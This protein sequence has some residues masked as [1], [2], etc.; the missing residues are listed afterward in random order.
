MFDLDRFIRENIKNLIPYASARS[1]HSRKDEVFL[2][3]NENSMGD[4]STMVEG[5]HPGMNR[6]P[7]PFQKVLKEKISG[8]KGVPT[9][10]IFIGN[11]SDEA[12]DLIFRIFC[13]PGKDR[14]II[15]PPTYGMYEV[16][17]N[18]NDVRVCKV[19][20]DSRF[21]PDSKTIMESI[22]GQTKLIFLCSPN[23][24]SGNLVNREII[25]RLAASFNGI[26]VVDEAYIDFSGEKSLVEDLYSRPNVIIL[27]TLSKAWAMAGLRIGMAFASKPIIDLFNKVKP[28]YNISTASQIMAI[29]ALNNVGIK[30]QW[31]R[32]ILIERDRLS[33]ELSRISYVIRIYPSDANYILVR[34]SDHNQVY[35][36]L[37]E[38]KIV[39][40]DRSSY[41]GCEGCL[42]ITIGT[43][44]END[45]VLETLKR[46]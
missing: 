46:F 10:N 34:F 2:D 15:C 7:D 19:N 17:A 35:K 6:Y 38:N 31:L 14:V 43:R 44:E 36:A 3:A 8:V 40:R 11:G 18:I 41:P 39:V 22:D 29:K 27:Q 5:F 20:L 13:S 42:R 12:I 1:E 32:T 33:C 16:I 9:G 26:L 28:P 37:L 30:N 23:N 24:P 45:R 4:F 21:Q 25:N